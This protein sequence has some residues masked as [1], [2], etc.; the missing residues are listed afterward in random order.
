[1]LF[2]ANNKEPSPG[3]WWVMLDGR[4]MTQNSP[5]G[6]KG[7]PAA[8]G[9]PAFLSFSSAAAVNT[10]ATGT[11]QHQHSLLK[12]SYLMAAQHSTTGVSL[13]SKAACMQASM[14]VL[15]SCVSS[16]GNVHLSTF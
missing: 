13:G 15:G 11:K 2:W 6:C 16:L 3:K 5:T 14:R 8:G 12:N 7:L 10:Q 9:W 1:M 4:L